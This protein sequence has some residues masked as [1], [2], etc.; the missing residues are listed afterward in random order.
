MINI[1]Y[2]G[3]LYCIACVL[4]LLAV[5]VIVAV[6]A[7]PNNINSSLAIDFN[8]S[9]A[10]VDTPY[11]TVNISSAPLNT[12][13]SRYIYQ[14][15]TVYLGDTIDISGVVA[16]YPELAYWNGYDM[17]DSQPT[18]NIS[19][20]DKRSGWY[21]F[22]IDPAIFAGRLGN[23][24]KYNNQFEHSGNNLAFV[25]L[26]RPFYNYTL[27]FQNGTT[28]YVSELP[29]FERL[30]QIK[31]PVPEIMPRKPVSD[32]L[33]T[34]GT[35]LNISITKLSAVWIFDGHDNSILYA[36]GND[37]EIVFN[38]S[39]I[40]SLEQGDY[41]ILIQSIGNI[42]NNMD[43]IFTDNSIKW[44]DRSAFV[45]RTI[46]TQNLV[47]SEAIRTLE[48]IFPLTYDTYQIKTLSVQD[49]MIT[50]DYMN[51]IG[52]GSAKEYYS[53]YS[54][55]GNIS[56]MDVRG[57]TNVF[58]GTNVSVVLD[59]ES[60]NPREISKLY[61]Y[62]STSQ[63]DFLG[64]MRYYQVYVP[65]YWDGL[66][67]GMHSLTARTELGGTMVANFPVTEDS[68]DSYIPP[69]TIKFMGDRN[70]WVPTPTPEIIIQKETVV[71]TQQVPIQIQP[72][73]AQI[74]EAA[75]KIV[76]AQNRRNEILIVLVIIGLFGIAFVCWIAWSLWRAK[77]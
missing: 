69:Q 12:T 60:N 6:Y 7:E 65:L 43:V 27:T 32:Y 56:L 50:I 76:D 54:R 44:F 41:K 51:R 21:K 39:Q 48:S 19:L 16:P 15:E 63:G 22:V 40:G 23:W 4:L 67:P 62:R 47:P 73:E 1:N 64:D 30:P 42:S 53:D 8:G 46:S 24:Y 52:V 33:V 77:R 29:E 10:I 18:Y 3:I 25:V 34:S 75:Q 74:S 38:S 71:V 14:G 57:Y 61:T 17:Y 35:S 28:I 45:V 11:G 66:K 49:P 59:E 36:I 2:R 26:P 13:S 72:S 31:N 37:K 20:P 5:F 55:S 9:Y 70:P 58:P 68:P